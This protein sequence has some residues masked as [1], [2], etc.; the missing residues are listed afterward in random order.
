MLRQVQHRRQTS[1]HGWRDGTRLLIALRSTRHHVESSGRRTPRNRKSRF[2]P[3]A[4]VTL[5]WA[6]RILGG[7]TL[8]TLYHK[9]KNQR[10]GKCRRKGK[11][12]NQSW[13]VFDRG[14]QEQPRRCLVLT[15]IPAQP[16]PRSP[17][18]SPGSGA[19]SASCQRFSGTRK[20][21]TSNSL[22]GLIQTAR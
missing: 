20:S 7:S 21:C 8:V 1:G 6:I 11:F 17:S 10:Q 22:S 12:H 9:K 2:T 19:S 15:H 3:A 18:T 13:R 14:R 4:Q 16:Q 5:S